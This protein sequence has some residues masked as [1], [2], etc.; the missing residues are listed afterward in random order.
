MIA[1]KKNRTTLLLITVTCLLVG[2]LLGIQYLSNQQ[3]SQKDNQDVTL[4]R[5]ELQKKRENNM[6]LQADIEKSHGLL[7]QYRSSIKEADSFSVIQEEIERLQTL[8]GSAGVEGQGLIVRIEDIPYDDNDSYFENYFDEIVY[9]DDLRYLVN[10][11]FASGARHM[12]LNGHR[13]TPT[14]YIRT[15]GDNILIDTIPINTP[16]IIEAIGDPALLESS[17]KIKGFEEYFSIMNKQLVLERIDK[18]RISPFRGSPY[19]R[20][21]KP[22]EEK[23]S[24]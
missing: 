8:T 15:V 14:T 2:Y 20:E 23:T 7:Q 9:D 21:M 5:Q 12:A 1:A 17:I 3:E 10:E 19:I 11:L 24:G 6:N 4:L 13:I 16:Y 22:L 18:M